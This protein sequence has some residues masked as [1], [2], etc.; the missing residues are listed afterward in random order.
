MATGS[1]KY[2]V[3]IDHASALRGGRR[4]D[5]LTWVL[6]RGYFLDP[7]RASAARKLAERIEH[8]HPAVECVPFAWHYLTHESTDGISARGGRK[9]QGAKSG[10]GHLKETAEVDQA[11]N[12]VEICSEAMGSKRVVLNTPAS[13]SP[14]AHYRRRLERFVAAHPD[15]EFLWQPSGLWTPP[16]AA[17][18]AK[19]LNVQVLGAPA[20]PTEREDAG[21]AEHWQLISGAKDARLSAAHAE[22]LAD[23]LLDVVE[24]GEVPHLIFS[25]PRAYSNL[26]TFRNEWERL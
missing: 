10:M 18:F 11:W 24:Q 26:R 22:I 21:P 17:Q 19:E 6:L 23:S 25:G 9:L 20:S 13:F 4:D 1:P 8:A 3:V 7:P 14:S 12:I 16:A 2:G 5:S 15:Y